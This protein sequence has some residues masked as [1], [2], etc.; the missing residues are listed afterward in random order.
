[1][2][3][4]TII[5]NAL[6]LLMLCA[7]VNPMSAQS[8]QTN[9]WYFGQNAGLDFS[10][11]TPVADISALTNSTI[12]MREGVTTQC[13]ANGNLLFYAQW[14]KIWDSN[15]NLVT[16]SLAG[17][18]SGTQTVVSFPHPL[19][20]N[21]Y[22]V[23]ALAGPQV[24]N[25]LSYTTLTVNPA[26][27]A[28]TVGSLNT[29]VTLPSGYAGFMEGMAVVGNSTQTGYFLIVRGY[30]TYPGF[31]GGANTT[32]MIVY[33]VTGGAPFVVG[34]PLTLAM[35]G[36]VG[37]INISPN[38]TQVVACGKD[39][40]PIP[41]TSQSVLMDFNP[42]SGVISNPLVIN[43]GNYSACFSP[44]SRVLYVSDGGTYGFPNTPQHIYQYDITNA[45][46]ISTEILVAT[47]A[48][49]ESILE[50]GPDDKIYIS[51]FGDDHLAVIEEP[52]D[53]NSTTT[54][55]ECSY[56]FNG[57]NL[58]TIPT[59]NIVSRYGLPSTTKNG[60][61]PCGL[62]ADFMELPVSCGV[63]LMDQSQSNSFTNISGWL[64]NFGD[65]TSSTEQNP[66]HYYPNPGW[67]TVCLTVTGFNGTD[68]CEEFF[69]RDIFVDCMDPCTIAAQANYTSF[70]ATCNYQFDGSIL[71]TN[72]NIIG[73]YWDFDDGT[74]ASGQNV[75]HV[76]TTNG[77]YDVCLTV[78]GLDPMAGGCCTTT[79]CQQISV[80][81]ALKM[82]VDDGVKEEETHAT[83]T[84]NILKVYPNPGSGVYF[85][86]LSNLAMARISI[87]DIVGRQVL[88]LSTAGGSSKSLDL[89]DAPNGIYFV[90]VLQE[91]QIYT[92]KL[93]KE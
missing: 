16:S 3:R 23:F 84:V 9:F 22:Y 36:D 4:T 61:G 69:C 38:G 33:S 6:V 47:V 86:E 90:R 13:D 93:I 85:L 42:T 48:E 40:K 2:K 27:L 68:C 37:A 49:P 24:G 55:N 73:W 39:Y 88:E 71:N 46:P 14:D 57:P 18:S 21:T 52:N 58:R 25:N 43:R 62:T 8:S 78:I 19:L 15:H 7:W 83:Q 44:D 67:Y 87:T 65:G 80:T 1:M 50:L 72:R 66:T 79:V 28:V 81:C 56:N 41:S 31:A 45:N 30:T 75:S 34:S 54:S 76:Y 70:P 89:S 10:S 82:Y 35:D 17:F 26:T 64:W 53:L 63:E 92:V 77:T 12:N 32:S 60:F 20:A 5:Y 91:E 59:Q 29:P 74:L 11:G 51:L